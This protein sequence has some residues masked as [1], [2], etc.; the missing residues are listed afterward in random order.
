MA[1]DKLTEYDATAA[2]NTVVGDVN[3]AEN[4]CLPSDVNNAI[5]EVMSHLKA[6][7]NGTD[8]IDAL[9]VD[10]NTTFSGDVSFTGANYHLQW[11]KSDN[12]LEFADNARARFGDS[13][14]LQIYHT[15]VQS[16]ILDIGSGDLWIGGDANINIA[17]AALNE[18][19]AV[20]A[21]IKARLPSSKLD[22]GFFFLFA[23][24]ANSSNCNL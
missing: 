11:D 3:L 19:K 16:Q 6:F 17:N 2:N 5:R 23:Y 14:D 9:Q 20:F 10:G 7:S 4:S 1:K 13:N 8:A 12:S 21:T 22:I 18:F 15:G 24:K